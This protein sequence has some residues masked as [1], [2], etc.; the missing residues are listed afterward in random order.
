MN[1]EGT[2]SNAAHLRRLAAARS[3]L[4]GNI[5]HLCTGFEKGSQDLTAAISGVGAFASQVTHASAGL[6]ATIHKHPLLSVG[7]AAAA[8]WVVARAFGPHATVSAR[9][10]S[11]RDSR[12]LSGET[13]L[14]SLLL[15]GLAGVAP[16]L[17]DTLMTEVLTP[18]QPTDTV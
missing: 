10:E 11:F 13:T 7:G 5:A 1:I 6:R 16:V 15:R 9:P 18:P 12:A 2:S 3:R 17:L 14:K 4:K 8:G